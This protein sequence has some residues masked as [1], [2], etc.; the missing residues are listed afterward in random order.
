MTERPP[1]LYQ[2]IQNE[3]WLRTFCTYKQ[4]RAI[5]HWAENHRDQQPVKIE[6]EEGDENQS[7]ITLHIEGGSK[8]T[9]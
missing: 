6:I 4:E 9:F 5:L 7:F 8:I 2:L 1:R 3:N